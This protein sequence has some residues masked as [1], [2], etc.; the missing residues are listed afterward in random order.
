MYR[1]MNTEIRDGTSIDQCVWKGYECLPILLFEFVYNLHLYTIIT[2][3]T[4][5]ASADTIPN[6]EYHFPLI[7]LYFS[8]LT[9]SPSFFLSTVFFTAS[10]SVSKCCHA[11]ISIHNFVIVNLHVLVKSREKERGREWESVWKWKGERGYSIENYYLQNLQGNL[12]ANLW[13]TSSLCAVNFMEFDRSWSLLR[14]NYG[15]KCLESNLHTNNAMPAC[16]PAWSIS[17]CN[18]H[19]NLCAY[20][21]VNT[22]WKRANQ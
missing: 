10:S 9:L 3:F 18:A 6:F 11:N 8:F 14:L 20:E 22:Y 13:Q 17:V 15:K 4:I 19:I 2:I 21:I 1:Q 12:P 16:L 5:H 7:L